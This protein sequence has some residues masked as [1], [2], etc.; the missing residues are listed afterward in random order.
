[1]E[2]DAAFFLHTLSRF[3]QRSCKVVLRVEILLQ[4]HAHT[5][6]HAHT[7]AHTHTHTRLLS[8][9][10]THIIKRRRERRPAG[11]SEER[12]EGRRV[13]IS[14][15]LWLPSCSGSSA[16]SQTTG[17]PISSPVAPR[18]AEGRS[19]S[20]RTTLAERGDATAS[21]SD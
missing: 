9:T 6:T 11:W 1:M 19:R 14:S 12:G 21:T 10:H 16:P 18:P 2:G 8:H 4:S 5:H 17:R 3:F 13:M 15:R 20:Q 7:H